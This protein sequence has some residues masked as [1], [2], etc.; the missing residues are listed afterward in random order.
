MSNIN[1][2]NA[3]NYGK[4]CRGSRLE[5]KVCYNSKQDNSILKGVGEIITYAFY[6]AALFACLFVGMSLFA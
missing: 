1:C 5:P 6:F 3:K 4:Y 2:P